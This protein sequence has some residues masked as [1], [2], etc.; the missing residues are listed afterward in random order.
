MSAPVGGAGTVSTGYGA[1]A[2]LTDV[3]NAQLMWTAKARTPATSD[4][5]QQV[6]DLLTSLLGAAKQSGMF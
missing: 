6:D 3:S 4:Q 2:V 1:N 5:G